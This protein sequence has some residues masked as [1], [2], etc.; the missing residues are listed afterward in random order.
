LNPTKKEAMKKIL[1]AGIIYPISDS[2]QVS[3]VQVIPKIGGMKVI[4]NEKNEFIPT[5]TVLGWRV[6]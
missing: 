4:H 5:R 3:L 1:K 2:A 6:H